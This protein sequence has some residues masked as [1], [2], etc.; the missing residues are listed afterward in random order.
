MKLSVLDQSP[1]SRG[2]TAQ[3]ALNHTVELAK[4]TEQ[5]G[6]YRYW[7]AE[8][9]S[10]NGLAATAP[11]LLIGQVAAHTN[12]IRVGSGGVLLPQYS[13]LKVAEN[14][15]ML[16]A[17]YPGR[18]DL[19]IGRSPGGPEK[20]RLALTDGKSSNL[21]S[22]PRQLKDLQG[23]LHNSLDQDHPYR[24][25]KAGPRVEAVPDMWVLGLSERSA[26]HAAS[27]G[28]G[29]TYGHFINPN[30]GIKAINEYRKRFKPSTGLSQP[31]TNVCIF[32]VCADTQDEA[33]ELALSQDLWLLNVG[34]GRDT[35][36]PSINEVRQR[37]LNEEDI[38]V[39]KE[40]RKR[41]IIG[42]PA[43]VKEQ[44]IKYINMYQVD[45]F[46]IITHIDDFDAKV[47]SYQLIA[48]AFSLSHNKYI[49]LPIMVKIYSMDL[50]I[51]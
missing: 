30:Q 7:I 24:T 2:S 23:F 20:V 38:H 28:I 41:A 10:T 17:F 47:R 3:E 1:I 49:I 26:K 39:M 15:K 29:F 40:N 21:G 16:S 22:F 43:Q 9:H 13:P 42:T 33:E 37:A 31:Q 35:V 51:K 50:T 5:L 34:K 19:G 46:L 32:V 27:L 11:E 48:E 36:V 18:I 45:E 8:H 44:L 4:I 12:E 6:Y 25:V 14:F